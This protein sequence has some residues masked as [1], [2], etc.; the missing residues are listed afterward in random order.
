MDYICIAAGSFHQGNEDIFGESSNKQCVL[1]AS[2]ALAWRSVGGEFGTASIDAI[3][4]TGDI[5]YRTVRTAREEGILIYLEPEEV[6]RN[7]N[8]LGEDVTIFDI[9]NVH[10]ALWPRTSADVG[11]SVQELGETL[12]VLMAEER[13]DIGFLFTGQ[14]VTVSF[15][16]EGGLCYVFDSHPVNERRRHD[17]ECE[18]RNLARI[19]KCDSILILARVLLLNAALDGRIRQYSIHQLS[20][21]R[22]ATSSTLLRAEIAPVVPEPGVVDTVEADDDTSCTASKRRRG[23]PK[24]VQRGRPKTLNTTR[25]EQVRTASKRYAQNNPDVNRDAVRRYTERNPDVNRESVRR[26][27]QENPEVNRESVRR[28]TQENPEVHRES[29]RRFTQK[30]PEVHRESVRRYTQ[31][32]PEVHRESV[33][34]YTQENPEVHR[35]SVR[36]YT[37]ENPEVHRASVSRY[38][39][40]HPAERAERVQRFRVNN[41]TLVQIRH[42]PKASARLIVEHGPMAYWDESLLTNVAPHK[43]QKPG[44]GAADIYRCVHCGARLYEEEKERKKWCCGEGAYNVQRLAPLEASFYHNRQFLDR[45]RAYNDMFSFCA[46]EVSG[47]YRHPSGLAFFKIEGRMYHQVHA[48]NAPGQRFTTR[49]GVAQFVNRCRLYIDDGEERRNLAAGRSLDPRVIDSISNFLLDKNPFVPEFRMLSRE[50]SISAHLEFE[51]TSRATHGPVLGDRQTGV[52]VHA[53]LST[54]ETVSDPRRLSV[55]KVGSGQPTTIDLFSPLMEPFQY[56]LLYPEGNP[57]WYINRLDN[58]GRKLSQFNYA[59]C[60]LLSEPRFSHF[61]RLS[62]AWQVE[63]FARFEEERLRFIKRVQL[64]GLGGLRMGP[65]DELVQPGQGRQV[66]GDIVHDETIQGEGGAQPGKIYLPSSFTGGPRYMKVH[67]ENA[68]GLVT[69]KGPPTY[70]LTFTYSAQWEEHKAACTDGC[71]RV[72]P[73]S[74]CRIFKIK[75][76]ELIRDLRTGAMF[77]RQSYIVYVIEMQMRGLPHAHIVFKIEGDGPVQGPEIDSVIWAVIPSPDVAGGRLRKLVLQHMIHGPCGTDYRTDFLCW[78]S[79]KGYCTKFFPKPASPTTHVDERGFVQYRRDY[80]NKGLVSARNRN[81]EVHDGWVVP[82]NPALL[83]KYEAH[84]NLELASTRRVIKYLFKYLMKGGSLQNV[85]VM[86]L[87][88]QDDEVQQYVTKRMIG[89]SDACWRLLDFGLSKSEPTVECLPVHLEGKQTVMFRPGQLDNAVQQS[90]SKLIIYF[91][92]PSDSILDDV[93]YPSFYENYMIHASRPRNP[94][95]TLFEHPDGVHFI[96]PRQRGEKVCRLIWVSPNRGEQYFLRILLLV[97]P[98]RGY[99]DLLSRGGTGCTTFQEVARH[100]GLV[101]DDREYHLALREAAAFMVGSRLRSFFVLLCNMGAP[102]FLLWGEFR[103]VLCEDHL[104]RNPLDPELAYKLSLLEIDRSLRRQ[105]SCLTDHGLP[106]VADDSTELGRELLAYGEN[107]QGSIVDEWLPRLSPDQRMV[108]DH[109]QNLLGGS[110]NAQTSRVLFLDGPGGYGKTQLI[111]VILAFVRS[112]GHVAIA[113]ASSGIA[114]GNMPG[115]TTAHSMFR[116]P[117]DLGQ[118]VGVWN[119]TNGSQRAELIRAA[120][121]IVFDEAPMAHRYIFEMLDRSLRD[122]MN[123]ETPFGGKI[124]LC[125]GDFRQIAPVVEKARTPLDV[126]C[127]SLRASPLWRLFN[128]FH[129][130][131]PQRTRGTSFYSD[132][133]L[134]VGNGTL[135]TETFGEGRESQT[136]VPLTDV[137]VMTNIEDLIADVFP[138]NILRDSDQSARRAI[139]APLNVNVKNINERILGM[140][141]GQLHELLSADSV[142]REDEDSLDAD[143][144]IVNQATGKGVPDHILRLKIGSVCLIMRNLNIADGL[145]NGTKVILTAISPRLITVRM[146]GGTQLYGIPRIIFKFAMVEGSPLRISRRQFPLMLAYA[147]SGHKSQG[148]T[149]DYVGVDLRTDCFT[150]GQ[151]YVLLSRVRSPQDIVVLVPENRVHAGVAYVKNIVYNELLL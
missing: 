50:T 64:G 67:Y 54:E 34:R 119:I 84:I 17:F 1:N 151:L 88:Q 14:C 41:P 141:E 120:Q 42:L 49:G 8:I 140:L 73:A 11:R 46:L 118:G 19:F 77:G 61:G 136:L 33:R 40:Q 76:Q 96:T 133:L 36:R 121:L 35:E 112:Q 29:V 48:L 85:T 2:V 75:L 87:G 55:W 102:A 122:L 58:N 137:R 93:T 12:E 18:E 3:L 6:P 106:Y 37:Q 146:P 105:G 103:D 83:L 38:D 66:Q 116:L 21:G 109:I 142:D 131:T 57:G 81:I 15:W 148:Q 22:P 59:R 26:Y 74:A 138:A 7:I 104:E 114:A 89:A 139:L 91:Q 27:T 16:R 68:M 45:A 113:V 10:N 72:D 51:V 108:F 69:R 149:I 71:G 63:M 127:V 13:R 23:R 70:F 100:L 125:S 144:Q 126:V 47:G 97:I 143:I 95:G 65:L 99:S 147:M 53:V 98:C 60:L 79:Q 86:P 5:L 30:N 80:G 150:H 132:F 92:R 107:L 43:L 129:L 39:G 62:Q 110:A 28:Y 145:V 90:T 115:G 4:Y 9:L 123:S 124:F 20:F 44:L 130:V 78:D 25:T 94:S 31:E 32:N 24:K 111:R 56:P 117:L 134:Q 52:E 135:P 101:N 128:V 82:Y